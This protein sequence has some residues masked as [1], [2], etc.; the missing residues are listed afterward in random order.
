[1]PPDE[2]SER[3]SDPRFAAAE[4]SVVLALEA[5]IRSIVVQLPGSDASPLHASPETLEAL[6]GCVAEYTA[7]LRLRN[8][9]PERVLV[10]FK[11]ILVD[12]VP[13]DLDVDAFKQ[14]AITWCIKAYYASE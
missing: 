7:T 6:R 2:I 5:C 9:A 4:H 1:M 8:E 12:V 10:G 14:A 3:V 11:S 13:K